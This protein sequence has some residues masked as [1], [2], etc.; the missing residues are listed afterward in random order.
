MVLAFNE[1]Y[2]EVVK[3]LLQL[4]IKEN[5][6]YQSTLQYLDEQFEKYKIPDLHRINIL[7]N[8]LPA[9]TTQF[10]IAAMQLAV[11][12]TNK[13]LFFDI[14]LENLKKQGL[15]MDANI[16]GIKEQT[17]T[18]RLKNQELTEQLPDK[19]ENLKL[20]NNLLKAQIDKLAKEQKLAESQQRAID[21]QV[22]D[23]R[24]IKAFSSLFAHNAETLNGGL[25]LPEGLV[26]LPFDL[27]HELIKNDITLSK[28]TTYNIVKRP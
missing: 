5:T 12:L 28:P 8:M 7:S 13:A 18:T 10:T 25:V 22:K 15:A 21:Q 20:Q 16:E 1:K 26:K 19:N 23:N 9:I 4:S 17:Q 6:P 14:E 3:N 2:D 24:V 11:E 27:V